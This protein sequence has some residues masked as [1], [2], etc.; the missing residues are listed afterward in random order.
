MAHFGR[1]NMDV[2]C[3][4]VE[5]WLTNLRKWAEKPEARTW[6]ESSNEDGFVHDFSALA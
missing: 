3:N 2:S 4:G 5:K 1:R 6:R